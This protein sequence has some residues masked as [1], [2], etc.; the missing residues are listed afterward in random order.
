MKFPAL[1]SVFVLWSSASLTLA[2]PPGH[3]P[4]ADRY[5]AILDRLE[6][7]TTITL[8]DWRFHADVPHPEDPALNDSGW[9]TVK[10]DQLWSSGS[11]VLRGWIEI[12]EKVHGYSTLGAK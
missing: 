4:A 2:Q 9:A 6:S 1:L 12:P 10:T 11:R 5:K 8:P 7:L 3:G